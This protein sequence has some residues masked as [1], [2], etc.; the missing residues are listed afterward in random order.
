MMLMYHF[1]VIH[2]GPMSDDAV[3]NQLLSPHVCQAMPLFG[4]WLK[5]MAL[6]LMVFASN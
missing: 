1:Y 3:L 4:L 6:K 5:K 2:M